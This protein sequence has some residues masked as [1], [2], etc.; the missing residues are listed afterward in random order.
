MAVFMLSFC[1]FNI[2]QIDRTVNGNWNSELVVKRHVI[3][4]NDGMKNVDL[5]DS[6]WN[7]VNSMPYGEKCSRFASFTFMNGTI[8][9]DTYAQ[10]TKQRNN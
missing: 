1:Q 4:M 3:P 8:D 5:P 10:C 7:N 9:Q 2:E 6:K